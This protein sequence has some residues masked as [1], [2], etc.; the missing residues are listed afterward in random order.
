MPKLL[1]YLRLLYYNVW[2]QRNDWRTV[3]GELKMKWLRFKEE[4]ESDE[5]LTNYP[6][7]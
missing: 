2:H 7:G 5:T 6:F 4:I 3:E 1:C